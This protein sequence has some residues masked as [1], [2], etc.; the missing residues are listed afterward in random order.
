[1]SREE[2]PTSSSTHVI[3]VAATADQAVTPRPRASS[4]SRR[5]TAQNHAI[6]SRPT[7]DMRPNAAMPVSEPAM[8]TAYA[9]SGGMLRRRLPSGRASVVISATTLAIRMGRTMKLVSALRLSSRPKKI[10]SPG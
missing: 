1:M 2:V 8:S 5:A 3:A 7:A 4:V 6:G 10:W 9:R